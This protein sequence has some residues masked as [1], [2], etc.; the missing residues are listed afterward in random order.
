MLRCSPYFKEEIP[1][2]K[3]V[4]LMKSKALTGNFIAFVIF[5]LLLLTTFFLPILITNMIFRY[6]HV[7]AWLIVYLVIVLSVCYGIREYRINLMVYYWIK[8]KF[9]V[10]IF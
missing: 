7:A 6:G 2:R 5:I 9:G 3:E 10:K 1:K 8:R 4:T